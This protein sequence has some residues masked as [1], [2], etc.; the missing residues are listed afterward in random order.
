MLQGAP[1]GWREV[2]RVFKECKVLLFCLHNRNSTDHK[3]QFVEDEGNIIFY[4]NAHGLATTRPKFTD[5]N[6]SDSGVEIDKL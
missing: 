2:Y 3:L 6:A 5:G 1:G 4:K